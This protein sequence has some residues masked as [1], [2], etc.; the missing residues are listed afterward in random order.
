MTRRVS[1]VVVS[2][3]QSS[4]TFQKP[5]DLPNAQSSVLLCRDLYL[6]LENKQKPTTGW[7]KYLRSTF[8][9]CIHILQSWLVGW[10]LPPI[11]TSAVTPVVPNGPSSQQR[12]CN[13]LGTKY[14]IDMR[15]KKSV[16]LSV[17]IIK[18][19]SSH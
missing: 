6:L 13:S 18:K 17:F 5:S 15:H 10:E 8:N 3:P 12:Q 7:E 1:A 19:F 2:S 11:S 4:Y 14:S 9:F 16:S